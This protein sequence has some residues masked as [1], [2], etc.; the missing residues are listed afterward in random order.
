MPFALPLFPISSISSRWK[1][2]GLL[3]KRQVFWVA[4]QK[5]RNIVARA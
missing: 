4:W 5:Q 2:L 3:C 1:M